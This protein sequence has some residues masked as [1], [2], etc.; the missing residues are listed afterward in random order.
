MKIK[1]CILALSVGFGLLLLCS[2]QPVNVQPASPDIIVSPVVVP[3]SEQFDIEL[4]TS[5][6]IT[7]V[8]TER[9][10]E[11][12]VRIVYENKEYPYAVRNITSE[13]I[14]NGIWIVT[15]EFNSFECKS[16]QYIFDE[17]NP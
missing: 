12:L 10:T 9:Y 1:R 13:Y 6:N 4:F 15:V 17:V 8:Y 7:E 5:C 11:E 2:C 16:K 3:S 14:Q